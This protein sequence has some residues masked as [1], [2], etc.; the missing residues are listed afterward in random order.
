[1]CLR[2]RAPWCD[3]LYRRERSPKRSLR[4]FLKR[5]KAART[6]RLSSVGI[7]S[8]ASGKLFQV[9]LA[10]IRIP[11]RNAHCRNC[12]ARRKRGSLQRGAWR[13]PID[14]VLNDWWLVGSVR[15]WITTHDRAAEGRASSVSAEIGSIGGRLSRGLRDM[16]ASSAFVF[17]P[18]LTGNLETWKQRA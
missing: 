18:P 16:A 4:R 1:M 7:R 12:A 9:G 3:R 5:S 2:L 8:I 11:D 14:A 15:L 17:E 13:N 10:A 6:R